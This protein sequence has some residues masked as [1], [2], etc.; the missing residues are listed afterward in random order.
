MNHQ[1]A[2]IRKVINQPPRSRKST[3]DDAESH[4]LLIGD[5]GTGKSQVLRFAASL[6]SRAVLTTGVGTT[7]AGLTCAAVRHGSTGEFTL[8]AG[9]LVL[10][11]QGVCCID[12]FGC[13]RDQ[14][15]TTIHEAMEQQ[16][17]SVAK[18]G[19]VCK[20]NCRATVIAVMN[21]RDSLYDNNASL[22]VNTGL[23]TPLL[24]RF[25][26]IFKLVDTSDSARDDSITTYLLNQAIKGGGEGYQLPVDENTSLAFSSHPFAAPWPIE[27]LRAYITIVKDIFRPVLS[28]EAAILLEH[29]YKACRA[30]PNRTI[31]VTVRFLE[32]LI[33]LSQA[34]ARLMFRDTVL[35]VDA[36]AVIR[37]TECSAFCFGGFDDPSVAHGIVS[38]CDSLYRDPMTMDFSDS[39]DSDL[40]IFQYRI[41]QRYKM[42]DMM[43]PEQCK[44][45]TCEHG[46]PPT[47]QSFQIE[48]EDHYGRSFFSQAATKRRRKS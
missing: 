26:L 19:I 45:A 47:E 11:D 40:L 42:L 25:D 36:V 44:A 31:P 9:A 16:H 39:A 4:L 10:A 15:R 48:M 41:L 27:K 20:L 14:D 24:S 34:H 33:R 22:T 2:L 46:G 32:S 23:A 7:S 17:L 18:G 6:C 43:T 30:C 37:L 21:P 5:P 13:I 1:P 8:E 29:H 3:R 12:E 38:D 35:L 28:D